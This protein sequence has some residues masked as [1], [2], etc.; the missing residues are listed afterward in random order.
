VE[1]QAAAATAVE[2]V[3]AMLATLRCLRQKLQWCRVRLKSG[4]GGGRSGYSIGCGGN[5]GNGNTD[6]NGNRGCEQQ[7]SKTSGSGSNGNR[8]VQEQRHQTG[9]PSWSS[10]LHFYLFLVHFYS[11]VDSIQF[12]STALVICRCATTFYAT[13]NI[14]NTQENKTKLPLIYHTVAFAT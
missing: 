4:R 14:H 7:S 10:L 12:L 5:S 11:V 8:G 2:V 9:S 1:T 3:A 6:N 13:I